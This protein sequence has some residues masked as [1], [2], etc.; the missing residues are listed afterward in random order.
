MTTERDSGG[1]G[2]GNDAESLNTINIRA[3]E[4]LRP[5][6]ACM[7]GIHHHKRQVRSCQTALDRRVSP[8]RT[9]E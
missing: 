1:L 3:A 6:K 9:P 8:N 4:I 7:N 2:A 5:V